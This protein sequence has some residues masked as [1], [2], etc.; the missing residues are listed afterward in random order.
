MS[1][2]KL[3]NELRRSKT[4]SMSSFI[5]PGERE[6][7]NTLFSVLSS[8]RRR[9][10]LYACNQVDGET[11]LSDV[12]E[13]V[14]AWEY[15][16]TAA[17]VT[18]TERKRVYT[19]IQQHHLPKLEAAGLLTIDGD[20]LSTTEKAENLDVYLEIVSEETIPWPIYYLGVSL[21]GFGLVGLHALSL[22]PEPVTLSMITVALLAIFLISSIVHLRQTGPINLG[23]AD[24][25]TEEIGSA[26]EIEQPDN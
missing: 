16:K 7:K 12:A 22:L 19:S 11:T 9:Y 26:N 23:S 14:A 15:D 4:P 2:T 25:P 1:T 10:V 24:A 13:Q 18:S 8:H 20:R 21:V 3:E 17:E 5:S 6:R